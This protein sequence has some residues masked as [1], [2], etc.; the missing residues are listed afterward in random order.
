MLI[1]RG[2]HA[3]AIAVNGLRID[4]PERS[5]AVRIAV[6]GHPAELTFR[7]DDVVF[8]T[9]K[10]QDTANA[11]GALSAAGGPEV[12]IVVAQNGV[13]NERVLLRHFRNVYAMHVIL[14]V[15]HSSL[16]SCSAIRL[17]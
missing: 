17:R 4:D 5:E 7:D 14:A 12:S 8:M 16:A 15:S 6:V 1:A 9:M 2:G 10:G 3:A 11:V 13:E